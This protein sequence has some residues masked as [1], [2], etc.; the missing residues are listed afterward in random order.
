MNQSLLPHITSRLFDTPLAIE[1]NKIRTII[2]ALKPR[3]G[4]DILSMPLPDG[5]MGAESEKRAPYQLVNGFGVIDVCGTLVCKASGLDAY[6]GLTSYEQLSAEFDQA[7][8]DSRVRTVA[9]RM[10]CY[11]GE[12]DGLFDFTDKVYAGR[13]TKPSIA[14]I[15]QKAFSA[16]YAIAAACGRIVIPQGGMAGSIGVIME[17]LDQTEQNKMIGWVIEEIYAGDRKVDTNPNVPLTD[18]SR[19]ALQATVDKFYDLFVSKVATYRGLSPER[20]RGTEAGVFVGD[21]AVRVGLADSVGTFESAIGAP[22]P[23]SEGETLTSAPYQVP[24][25]PEEASMKIDTIEALHKEFPDLCALLKADA[26]ETGRKESTAADCETAVKAEQ[27]RVKEILGLAGYALP[28]LVEESLFLNGGLT[29]D[30]FARVALEKKY[31]KT[32]ANA[33]AWLQDAQ[34]P[35]RIDPLQT[36]SSDITPS[37]AAVNKQLGLDNATFAKYATVNQ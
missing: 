22:A 10:H 21:T 32:Q 11:G 18:A 12:V 15:D 2:A 6:S 8:D 24:E 5:P 36:G 17:R 4:M 13:I 23:E 7:Q 31:E 37:Q 14:I 30:K 25:M 35:A 20:V 27:E 26:R 1:R 3:L 33:S 28:K 29:A 16:A 19:A 34:E 9:F